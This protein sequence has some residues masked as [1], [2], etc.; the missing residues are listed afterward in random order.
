MAPA[1]QLMAEWRPFSR[2]S[3]SI[4]RLLSGSSS[5]AFADLAPSGSLPGGVEGSRW[6]SPFSSG[7]QGPDRFFSFFL[8]SCMQTLRSG[9][10]LCILW[11]PFLI[12]SC[13]R[14]ELMQLSGLSFSKK[15]NSKPRV[16][17]ALHN[18]EVVFF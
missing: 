11:R 17:F 14:V 3:T 13:N 8:G 9:V 2:S 10:L 1:L 4:W 12:S 7:G 18:F 16:V 15:K 5:I 6:W